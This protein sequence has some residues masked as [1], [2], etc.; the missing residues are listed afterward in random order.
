MHLQCDTSNLNRDNTAVLLTASMPGQR[1]RRLP[2]HDLQHF[3]SAIPGCFTAAVLLN[4]RAYESTA[5]RCRQ[6]SSVVAQMHCW[7]GRRCCGLGP[8]SGVR[9]L[10][11]LLVAKVCKESRPAQQARRQGHTY[12]AVPALLTRKTMGLLA[13]LF[14]GTRFICEA[15]CQPIC[16]LDQ[17]VWPQGRHAHAQRGGPKQGD[18]ATKPCCD[19]AP[20]LRRSTGCPSA[21]PQPPQQAPAAAASARRPQARSQPLPSPSLRARSGLAARSLQNSLFTP[22][23]LPASSLSARMPAYCTCTAEHH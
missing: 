14:F 16:R 20:H 6:A 10:R 13:T 1:H 8:V 21:S 5:L 9:G 17:L 4:I 22:P 12:L 18:G 3:S 2:D 19:S 11:C 7:A 23:Y 15:G